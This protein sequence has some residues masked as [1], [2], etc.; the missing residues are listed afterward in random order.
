MAL[1]STLTH[2]RVVWLEVD[3]QGLATQPDAVR[4]ALIHHPG[5]QDL[6]RQA[7]GQACPGALW[8]SAEIG[9][10]EPLEMPFVWSALAR[11][12]QCAFSPQRE[13]LLERLP[14]ERLRAEALRLRHQARPNQAAH[15]NL[16]AATAP[17]RSNAA[18]TLASGLADADLSVLIACCRSPMN[19]IQADSG[20]LL[21]GHAGQ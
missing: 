20:T 21:L 2:A 10:V 12:Q 16:A 14:P 19:H 15:Q 13:A 11:L 18:I 7:L 8:R 6:E 4:N 5:L 17:Q 1:K 3:R 9:D